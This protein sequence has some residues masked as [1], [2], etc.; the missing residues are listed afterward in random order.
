MKS[1]TGRDFTCAPGTGRGPVKPS[2]RCDSGRGPEDAGDG[3]SSPG[4]APCRA[5]AFPRG[6]RP[7]DRSCAR[8]DRGRLPRPFPPP[9]SVLV[10]DTRRIRILLLGRAGMWR[11]PGRA[12]R[13]SRRAG[14][15]P[16]PIG[17]AGARAPDPT[18]AHRVSPSRPT[19]SASD[20]RGTASTPS[21]R[22]RPT[23]R[24]GVC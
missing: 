24:R 3:R 15:G 12:T 23:A 1:R 20:R 9:V 21:R 11:R 19:A 8:R 5:P 17:P 16:G 6:R 10:D 2:D 18:A 4:R 13:E 22:G 14:R 7:S